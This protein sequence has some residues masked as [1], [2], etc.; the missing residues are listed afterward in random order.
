MD[1]ATWKVRFV[2]KSHRWFG[3]FMVIFSQVVIGSGAVL[4]WKVEEN[5][6]LGWALAGISA[7][8]FFVLLLAFEIRH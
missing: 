3:R 1:W 4:H 7:S 2:G 8:L 6:S 5:I